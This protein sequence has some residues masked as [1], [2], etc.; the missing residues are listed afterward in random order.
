MSQEDRGIVI[1][2]TRYP[3]LG[4]H[5]LGAENDAR[6]FHHWLIDPAGGAVPAANT[7]LILSGDYDVFHHAE[8]AQPSGGDVE[9]A[10]DELETIAQGNRTQRV[11]RRLYLYFAGHGYVTPDAHSALL[12]ANATPVRIGHHV[13]ATAWA[14]LFLHCGY[15]HE[16]LLF[17]DCCRQYGLPP[18]SMNR[19]RW[20]QIAPADRPIPPRYFFAFAAVQG[21]IAQEREQHDGQFRGTFTRALLAGLRGGAVDSL[22]RVTAQ[23]LAAYLDQ[24]HPELL[25]EERPLIEGR[26]ECDF[27]LPHVDFVLVDRV[28]GVSNGSVES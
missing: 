25:P 18:D 17:M 11:G 16:V 28:G 8:Y 9:E 19:P 4:Q 2:V 5:L 20:L 10:F 14:R 26:A 3:G 27:N 6:A 22:G 13:L 12:M 24:P 7:R 15:F 1:G 23:S 21:G